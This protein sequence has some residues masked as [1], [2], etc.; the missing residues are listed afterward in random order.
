M[1]IRDALL[2]DYDHEMGTTRRLLERLPDDKLGWKPH[3]KSM[4]FGYLANMVATMPAWVAMGVTKS[5]LDVAPASGGGVD[6]AFTR[7]L[8]AG[9]LAGGS[10]GP[11][12]SRRVSSPALLTLLASALILAA[13]SLALLHLVR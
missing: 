11:I 12:I 8:V 7:P 5:E 2:A 9:G 1:A 4:I 13:I 3:E 10:V 6:W